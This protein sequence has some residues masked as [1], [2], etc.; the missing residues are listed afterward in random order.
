MAGRTPRPLLPTLLVAAA[1][2][3]A[4][5]APAS[6]TGVGTDASTT[7]ASPVSA[8]ASTSGGPSCRDAELGYEVQ[9]PQGW[10][11]NNG[12]VM[13]ACRLFDPDDVAVEPQTEVPFDIAI[14]MHGSSAPLEVFRTPNRASEVVSSWEATVDGHEAVVVEL[15]ATGDAMLPE[16]VHTYLY[17]V[18]L[19]DQRLVAATHES[20]TPA[21]DD[22]RQ[23]LDELMA[24][25]ETTAGS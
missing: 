18:E 22:T 3:T 12:E 2:A 21:H 20:G 25:L 17:A 4:C 23:V 10:Q 1:L 13:P 7:L 16:G 8:E 14:T 9:Y 6:G 19:G 5:G 24:G 15:R 11:T